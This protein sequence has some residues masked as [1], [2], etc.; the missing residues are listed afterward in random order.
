MSRPIKHITFDQSEGSVPGY[1]PEICATK[2]WMSSW[3][4]DAGLVIKELEKRTQYE[5]VRKFAETLHLFPAE[6]QFSRH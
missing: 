2:I 3:R 5:K 6:V 1:Y 4:T